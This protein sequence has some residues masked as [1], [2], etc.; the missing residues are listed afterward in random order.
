MSLRNETYFSTT[1][2][3]RLI[4]Q[5]TSK[6]TFLLDLHYRTVQENWSWTKDYM[7]SKHPINFHIKLIISL[8]KMDM[9]E[10]NRV[11]HCNFKILLAESPKLCSETKGATP[12]NT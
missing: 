9:T 4:F 6:S 12:V 8:I 7:R 2:S 3:T 5:C 10:H 11:Q 1:F